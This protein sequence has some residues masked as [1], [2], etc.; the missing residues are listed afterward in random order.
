LAHQPH[1]GFVHTTNL[2]SDLQLAFYQG[3]NNKGYE[4]DPTK[5]NGSNKRVNILSRQAN[6]KY[7]KGR[8]DEIERAI[9][10]ITDTVSA[11]AIVAVGGLISA[12][13]AAAYLS[14]IGSTIPLVIAVGRQATWGYS[15]VEGIYFDDFSGTANNSMQ[16]KVADLT[17]STK[18]AV[19]RD[20]IC[21]LYNDN[22]V[23]GSLELRDLTSILGTAPSSVDASNGGENKDIKLRNVFVRLGTP[24]HRPSSSARTPTS[25]SIFRRSFAWQEKERSSCAI[26]CLI[27]V[28]RLRTRTRPWIIS[29][30]GD[31][32]SRRCIPGSERLPGNVSKRRAG[33][34]TWSRLRQITSACRE[35]RNAALVRHAALIYARTI[36]CLKSPRR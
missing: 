16:K 2:D 14:R 36:R 4:A 5:L 8:P 11:Q 6:G 19:A 1:T 24:V 9:K 7:K 23:M 12:Q 33:H 3:L 21:F 30:P 28:T 26:P 34:S 35:E 17:S 18:Y 10:D 27:M 29:W 22:S 31:L 13:T 20:K 15:K 25:R 32:A